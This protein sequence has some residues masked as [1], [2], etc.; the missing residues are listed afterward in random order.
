MRVLIIAFQLG[1]T[2]GLPAGEV[3]VVS[4]PSLALQSRGSTDGCRRSH[5]IPWLARLSKGGAAPGTLT[6]AGVHS[7]LADRWLTYLFQEPQ[8]VAGK[9][10][11]YLP[12]ASQPGQ[13]VVFRAEMDAIPVSRPVRRTCCRSTATC[14][15]RRISKYY[16]FRRFDATTPFHGAVNGGFALSQSLHGIRSMKFEP[17]S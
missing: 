10:I 13:Y 4:Q 12:T 15:P 9:G 8:Y 16:S 5:S 6:V 14:Q 1:A 2:Y 7:A 3:Q 17:R 11:Q